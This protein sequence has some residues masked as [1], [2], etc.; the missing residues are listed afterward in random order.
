MV[1]TNWYFSLELLC[2]LQFITNFNVYMFH[3]HLD[4]GILAF[5]VDDIIF[6]THNLTLLVYFKNF[7]KDEYELIDLGNVHHYVSHEIIQFAWW[8]CI[9]KKWYLLYKLKKINMHD[10]KPTRTPMELGFHLLVRVFLLIWT[11]RN[12]TCLMFLI[13]LLVALLCGPWFGHNFIC[14]L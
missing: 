5:Y 3:K 14:F 10:C 13:N 12:N 9:T 11:R 4:F 7:L 6:T 1:S 8:I 2:F